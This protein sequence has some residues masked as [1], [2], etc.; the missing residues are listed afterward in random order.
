LSVILLFVY[1]NLFSKNN[2][3][4]PPAVFGINSIC[5]LLAESGLSQIS[6]ELNKLNN[7]NVIT[8]DS[9]T[10][11][12]TT[13][14]AVQNTS[15]ANDSTDNWANIQRLIGD[16]TT[17]NASNNNTTTAGEDA[18]TDQTIT[19]NS[20]GDET[21][22]NARND[23]TTSTSGATFNSIQTTTQ[24]N[25]NGVINRVITTTSESKI[26]PTAYP[27]DSAAQISIKNIDL[28]YTISVQSSAAKKV[29]FYIQKENTATP[30]YL[31]MA[32]LGQNNIW[33][34]SFNSQNYPNGSYSLYGL[35]TENNGIFQTPV[36]NFSINKLV[37]SSKPELETTPATQTMITHLDSAKQ[38][39][40]LIYKNIDQA[41]ESAVKEIN[42]NLNPQ[43]AKKL[44]PISMNWLKQFKRLNN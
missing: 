1:K 30:L 12:L 42:E 7:N 39:L 24:S 19:Q 9:I 18:N 8:N 14:G 16:E 43:E 27:I 35:L 5:N 44:I 34:Y 22:Q 6:Q 32:V 4:Q 10:Q 20:T 38:Q 3:R 25:S 11:T 26:L 29:E 37:V 40:D 2:Y 21:T 33:E 41:S 15:N 13:D 31:G 36:I 17:Q 28:I 23:N